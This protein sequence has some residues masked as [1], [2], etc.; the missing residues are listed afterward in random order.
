MGER[1]TPCVVVLAGLALGGLT[2]LLQGSL[3]DQAASLAN[4]AG[5]W[6]AAAFA[7][8]RLARHPWVAAA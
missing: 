3:P 7:L 8:A 4:S 5:P 6:C 2:S 1:W